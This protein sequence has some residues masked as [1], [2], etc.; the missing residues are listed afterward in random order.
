V[1]L[2]GMKTQ[3]NYGKLLT[4]LETYPRTNTKANANENV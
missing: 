2:Y 3:A 1:Q 4:I